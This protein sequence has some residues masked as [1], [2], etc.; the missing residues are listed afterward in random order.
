MKILQKPKY[1][2][3]DAKHFEPVVEGMHQVYTQGTASASQVKGIEICGK[4]GTAE[5]Y[6]RINGER[7]QLTDHS[8]FIAFAPKDDP[9]IALAVFIE[10]GYYGSRYAAKIAS[11]MIEK[12][13]RGTISRT[14]LQ[15]WIFTHSL[16]EEYAKP[17]SGEPF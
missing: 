7:M 3:I 9:K 8:V 16:E 4:T 5:N 12:Y 6:T 11:L 17:Y 15:E 2:T 10:N 1:T 13:V 14:D